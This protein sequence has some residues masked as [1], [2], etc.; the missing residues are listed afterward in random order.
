MSL[1]TTLCSIRGSAT[2]SLVPYFQNLDLR[3]PHK[4]VVSDKLVVNYV[5]SVRND[6][7]GA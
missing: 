3:T 1:T 2:P 4:V 6:V 7:C 5:R